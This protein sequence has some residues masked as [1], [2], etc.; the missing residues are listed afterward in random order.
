MELIPPH[1]T[2]DHGLDLGRWNLF[3]RGGISSIIPLHRPPLE[4][5]RRWNGRV[6]GD[7]IRVP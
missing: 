5:G 7:Q 3:H 2:F 1:S 4:G 6:N